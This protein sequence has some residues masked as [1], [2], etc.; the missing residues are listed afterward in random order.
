M[1][2]THGSRPTA[3]TSVI[4]RQRG[5]G[6]GGC[7]ALFLQASTA[8]TPRL[9]SCRGSQNGRKISG[10]QTGG[11]SDGQSPI[12][13]SRAGFLPHCRGRRP[14]RRVSRRVPVG[15]APR[16]PPLNRILTLFP[17]S[18]DTLPSGPSCPSLAS[19]EIVVW[20][21][22][23]LGTTKDFDRSD[24][25]CTRCGKTKRVIRATGVTWA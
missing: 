4:P 22:S 6:Q 1:G 14:L 24:R 9:R 16:L 2:L 20:G 5:A 18:H 12:C 7:I 21:T 8:V 3:H 13:G 19:Q 17:P 15:A 23:G 10:R 25:T 11:R